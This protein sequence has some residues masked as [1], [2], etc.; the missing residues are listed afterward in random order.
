MEWDIPLLSKERKKKRNENSLTV[1]AWGKGTSQTVGTG[2]EMGQPASCWLATRILGVTWA[3][4]KGCA[5]SRSDL[6]VGPSWGD[7]Y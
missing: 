2:E 3:R 1:Q 5:F 4:V 6:I 7:W